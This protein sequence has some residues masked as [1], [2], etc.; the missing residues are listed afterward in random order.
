MRTDEFLCR[1]LGMV[2][3]Y[4]WSGEAWWPVRSVAVAL[5]HTRKGRTMVERIERDVELEGFRCLRGSDLEDFKAG[6][7]RVYPLGRDVFEFLTAPDYPDGV[8]RR[9]RAHLSFM[10]FG[11]YLSAE[12]IVG[13]AQKFWLADTEGVYAILGLTRKVMGRKVGPLTLARM[14]GHLS[15]ALLEMVALQGLQDLRAQ[16]K[17]LMDQLE[18]QT[19]WWRGVLDQMVAGEYDRSSPLVS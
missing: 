18:E 5:G 19:R 8:K 14:E 7:E 11:Y 9:R 6:A 3:A 16:N 17:R 1:V 4:Y 13:R 15:R 2:P 10:E 12:E